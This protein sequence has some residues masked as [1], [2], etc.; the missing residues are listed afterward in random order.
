MG[1]SRRLIVLLVGSPKGLERSSSG[2]LAK[3]VTGILESRDW[4]CAP[5]HLHKTLADATLEAEMYRAIDASDAVL[6]SFPLYVDG[7]PGPVVEALERIASR[8]SARDTLRN[9]TQLVSIMNCGYLEPSHNFLA[10]RM[11]RAFSE[12]AGF[13]WF[14]AVALGMAGMLRR[15]LEEALAHVANALNDDVLMPDIVSHLTEKP[16]FPRWLYIMAGNAMWKRQAKRLG[17]ADRLRDRP[18]EKP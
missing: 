12:Q 2:R 17:A 8:E 14:G 5:F 4:D 10:A 6:L 13:V 7:L 1:D 15:R 18:Y 9:P 16:L 11:L 3:V